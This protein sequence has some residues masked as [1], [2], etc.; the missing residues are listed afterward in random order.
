MTSKP[1]NVQVDK[2]ENIL[3]KYNITFHSTIKMKPADVTS[4][5][6]IDFDVENKIA[7]LPIVILQIG[8]RRLL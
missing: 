1:K 7:F 8:H 2:L 5:T 3:D 6:Y 4:C